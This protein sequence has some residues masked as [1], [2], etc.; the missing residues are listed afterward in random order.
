[1]LPCFQVTW[2]KA[3]GTGSEK[4]RQKAMILSDTL[5]P[6]PF[7]PVTGTNNPPSCLLK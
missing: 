3:I 6:F 4:L 5:E 7:F 2:K 1:M